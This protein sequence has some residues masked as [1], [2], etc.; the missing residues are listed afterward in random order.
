[1]QCDLMLEEVIENM[2]LS[3][4]IKVRE[5]LAG[6]D[7]YGLIDGY[8]FGILISGT[9]KRMCFHCKRRVKLYPKK[10]KG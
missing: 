5:Q 8:I 6:T 3:E 1:M 2:R 7:K 4:L 9:Y 10:M